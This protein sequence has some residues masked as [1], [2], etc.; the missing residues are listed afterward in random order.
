MSEMT[1]Y[2][3]SLERS[4]SVACTVSETLREHPHAIVRYRDKEINNEAINAL[5][6]LENAVADPQ[7]NNFDSSQFQNC[8]ILKSK[9]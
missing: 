4:V 5:V 2:F 6:D 3:Q 7:N 8:C 9:D 1:P